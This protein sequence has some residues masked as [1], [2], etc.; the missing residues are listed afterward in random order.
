MKAYFQV[1]KEYEVT[2]EELES[3]SRETL[4]I[5]ADVPS[6]DV[7][8]YDSLSNARSFTRSSC[9]W[10]PAQTSIVWVSPLKPNYRFSRH[11]HGT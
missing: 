6:V 1:F 5:P 10:S 3:L 7:L 11:M 8:I 4:Y 9:F 2:A